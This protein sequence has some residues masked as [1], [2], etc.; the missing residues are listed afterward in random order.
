MYGYLPYGKEYDLPNNIFRIP[1]RMKGA[2]FTYPPPNAGLLL[3]GKYYTR[4]FH[5]LFDQ[6]EEISII[7]TEYA[8]HSSCPMKMCGV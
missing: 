2:D 8:P 3:L 4:M 5:A 6:S 7:S 1:V